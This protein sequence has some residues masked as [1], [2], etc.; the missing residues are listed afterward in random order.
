MTDSAVRVLGRAPLA[1][2]AL[3]GLS[4]A[5]G[6]LGCEEPSSAA[7]PVASAQ[8][9]AAAPTTSGAGASVTAAAAS[10]PASP[11]AAPDARESFAEQAFT[12]SLKGPATAKVGET[13]TL[14][15]RLEPAG[16]FKVNEEYPL[17]FTFSPTEGVA[18]IKAVVPRAD[19]HVDA[20]HASLPLQVTL[21][22]AGKREVLG[23]LAFSVCTEE[24]CLIEKRDLRALLDVR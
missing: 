22:S 12:L 1:R 3:L 13:V 11:E 24:R 17:K 6:L 9:A 8:A 19:A 15:V 2:C 21:Q 10:A 20:K 16:G 14:D 23:R 4:L 18:P 5:W 7:L